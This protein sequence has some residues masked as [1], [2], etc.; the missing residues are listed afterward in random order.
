MKMFV[1]F[2]TRRDRWKYLMREKQ[3][4]TEASQDEIISD[5]APV[6]KFLNI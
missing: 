5:I 3:L 6:G 4:F 2:H 1:I